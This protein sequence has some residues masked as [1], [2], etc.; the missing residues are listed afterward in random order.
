VQIKRRRII[1][2]VWKIVLTLLSIAT[3]SIILIIGANLIANQ[4]NIV[5]LEEQKNV[6]I[7]DDLIT[8]IETLERRLNELQSGEETFQNRTEEK[9]IG[10]LKR[11]ESSDNETKTK[12]YKLFTKILELGNQSLIAKE[13]LL[14]RLQV[15]EMEYKAKELKLANSIQKIAQQSLDISRRFFY[16]ENMTKIGDVELSN[17]ILIAENESMVR[18]KEME[19]EINQTI[20]EME[21]NYSESNTAK[22]LVLKNRTEMNKAKIEVLETSFNFSDLEVTRLQK[23]LHDLANDFSVNS[24]RLASFENATKLRYDELLNRIDVLA[25]NIDIGEEKISRDVFGVEQRSNFSHQE[26]QQQISDLSI[27]F[28]NS[29][30][31]N[32]ARFEK[33]ANELDNSKIEREIEQMTSK[34]ELLQGKVTEEIERLDSLNHRLRDTSAYSQLRGGTYFQSNSVYVHIKI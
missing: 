23:R 16:L 25:R 13:E 33:M 2:L 24:K 20:Q 3:L 31:E 15:W 9:V 18:E 17:R 28:E 32:K 8:R 27:K 12:S 26:I 4:R 10:L 21:R 11:L 30:E 29:L 7:K 1:Q 34:I 5:K 14:T 19:M 6:A 22:F